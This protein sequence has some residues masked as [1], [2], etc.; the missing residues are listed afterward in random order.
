M[1][2]VILKNAILVIII[3]VIFFCS[4]PESKSRCTEPRSAP[5]SDCIYVRIYDSNGNFV[6]QSTTTLGGMVYWDGR[7]CN[8]DSVPCG[9]YTAKSTVVYNGRSVTQTSEILVKRE[10]SISKTGRAACDSLKS[11]CNGF[12]YEALYEDPFTGTDVGCVC[13][14]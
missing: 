14:Q 12:Y 8:G 2:S 1:L 11:S 7:D 4:G 5:C 10:N 3:T 13:C 9:A 6:S